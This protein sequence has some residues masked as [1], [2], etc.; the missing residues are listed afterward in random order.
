MGQ[1]LLQFRRLGVLGGM[2]VE[3]TIEL[4]KRVHAATDAEDDQDHVP[5]LVDLNP[6]V[7]SRIRH[8]IEKDGENPGPEI[9]EMAKRLENAGAAALVMPCNSAHYYADFIENSVAVP[10][11]NMPQLTCMQIAALIEP[12]SQVG[13]LASPATN[14]TGLF[15]AF[16]KQVGL[17]AMYPE[18]ETPVL[19]SIRRIKKKGPAT[20]DLTLLE[21]ECEQLIARGASGIIVGCTEFSLLSNRISASVPIVDALDVLVDEIIAF[22]GAQPR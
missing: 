15:D 2:G 3:A 16:L 18:D 1:D 9:S 5:M 7:P 13:I 12:G 20:E 8:L 6:Q 22:S 10:L 17:I 11:L 21:R 14:Q 19:S 4:L